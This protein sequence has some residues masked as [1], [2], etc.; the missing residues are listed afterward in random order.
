MTLQRRGGGGYRLAVL[1]GVLV[2]PGLAAA[3]EQPLWEYGLGFGAVVLTDYPG[4]SSSHA[5]PVPFGY[6][7]YNGKILKSDNDGVRGLLFDRRWVE[8]SLSA[9][10]TAPVRNNA[11]RNGMPELRSTVE[12]GPSVNVHLFRSEE[13]RVKLD[14]KLPLRSAL[15]VAAPPR[16][17]GWVFEP[18]L[19]LDLQGIPHLPGWHVGVLAGPMFAD[20]KYHDYFYS[21]APQYALASRPEYAAPGGYSGTEIVGAISRHFPRFRFAA[22]VH[23]DTLSGASFEDSPLV[24]RRHDWS[25]GFGIAWTIGRSAQT[26]EVA[27]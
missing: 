5:Y 21:V 27:N 7:L 2:L 8:F 10:L 16:A 24:E 17:I 20:A 9:N 3:T 12:L 23:Y 18:S 25:G 4:A 14:L 13:D 26:V 6:F 11:A 15:T 1:L 19:D 22:Y